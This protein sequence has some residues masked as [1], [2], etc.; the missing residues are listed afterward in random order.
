MM[1]LKKQVK[2]LKSELA[3][4]DEEILSMKKNMKQTRTYEMEQEIKI[5]KDELLRLRYMCE[6]TL[7]GKDVSALK[8]S[9]DSYVGGGFI[10]TQNV[11][12][13]N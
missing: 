13:N 12:L 10:N 1:S 4:K 9:H 3:K 7:S 6:N 5:Y 8:N 2:E 11:F